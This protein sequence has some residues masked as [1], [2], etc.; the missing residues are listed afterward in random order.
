MV[1]IVWNL[2]R[3]SESRVSDSTLRLAYLSL[4]FPVFYLGTSWAISVMYW[5]KQFLGSGNASRVPAPG[6]VVSI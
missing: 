5:K 6:W 2:P 4:F 3:G 1:W